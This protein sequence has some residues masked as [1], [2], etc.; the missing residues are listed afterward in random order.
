MGVVVP[1]WRLVCVIA[2]LRWGDA[3]RGGSGKEKRG[4]EKEEVLFLLM[5]K[6]E[7]REAT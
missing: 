1:G 7:T 6:L 3:Q 2:S 5:E 4:V